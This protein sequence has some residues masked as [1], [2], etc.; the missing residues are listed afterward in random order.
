MH[1]RELI[2][3]TLNAI[4]FNVAWLLCVLGGDFV[5]LITAMVLLVFHLLIVSR[6]SQEFL[7]IIGVGIV[8]FIIDVLVFR[9]GLLLRANGISFPPLWLLALW[10][11]FATT[12]NHCFRF[13]Q[14]RLG[15]A[16]VAGAVSG[17]ASY[18][19]GARLSGVQLGVDF[20]IAVLTLAALWL[21]LFPLLMLA[22]REFSNV[23]FS[24]R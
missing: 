16:A 3:L 9:S 23:Y 24:D 6:V 5:A 14:Q 20:P 10:I 18:I 2:L 22:A 1:S 19:G 12:L 13:L 15:L 8:G 4:L 7:F 17:T 21:C 11:C